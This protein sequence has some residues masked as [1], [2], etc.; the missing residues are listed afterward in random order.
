MTATLGTFESK[1]SLQSSSRGDTAVAD[2]LMGAVYDY[3]DADPRSQQTSIGLSEIGHPCPRR[4]A[5]K[6]AGMPEPE[7]AADDPWLMILGTAFDAWLMKAMGHANTKLGRERFVTQKRVYLRPDKPGSLD[8]YDRETFTI[9]D[10]K[11]VG[12]S[13]QDKYRKQISTEYRTQV[14]CYGQGMVNQ[15]YR[16]DR[17]AVAMFPRFT[18]LRKAMFVWS[19]DFDPAVPASA[20]ARVDTIQQ[21]VT[22][23]NPVQDPAQFTRFPRRS[24]NCIWCPF[25]RPSTGKDDPDTGATCP[26]EEKKR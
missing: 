26:G 16:V 21:V 9:I 22:Q 24:S 2:V 19:E 12:K 4:L 18:W 7:N 13:S 25:Y 14:H 6:L 10:A 3:N 23:L 15:G 5:Y 8:I 17:V 11:L 20:L 1:A